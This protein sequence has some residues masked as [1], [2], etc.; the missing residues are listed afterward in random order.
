MILTIFVFFLPG[1]ISGS[2]FYDDG[3]LEV[4]EITLE[5]NIVFSEKSIR[6]LLP[7]KGTK[8]DEE[9]FKVSIER[10]INFY[11]DKGFPFVQVKPVQC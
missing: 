10:I 8:F 7:K 1:E 11:L 5:G 2:S 3:T 9:L 4:G 6:S